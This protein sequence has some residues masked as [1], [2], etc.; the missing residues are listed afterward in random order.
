[1]SEEELFNMNKVAFA[2]LGRRYQY[3]YAE[4][5]FKENQLFKL[6]TDFWF[7]I[8]FKKGFNSKLFKSII[9][10]RNSMIP[11]QLVE[12]FNFLGIKQ[13]YELRKCNDINELSLVLTK[14]GEKFSTM[15]KKYE[16]ADTIIGM[17]SESLE[18]FTHYKDK[19]KETILI[20]YDSADDEYIFSDEKNK[21]PDWKSSFFNR[22]KKYYSRVYRE[23]DLADK[24]IV[25]STWTKNLI[26]NQGACEKKIHVIP[27]IHEKN[28]FLLES[29]SVNKKNTIKVLY[30]GSIVLRKGVQYLLEATN[31]LDNNK[32]EFHIIGSS[33][34]SHDT[35]RSMYP[36]VNFY[37]HVPFS[38]V[39]HFYKDSDVLVFPTLSDGFG[40]VQVE[41][42]SYGIPVIATTS[43]GDV[44]EHGCSG[45]LIP[46]NNSLEIENYL[47]LFEDDRELL[48]QMKINAKRRSKD[49][50]LENISN[51][52]IEILKK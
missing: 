17:C 47:R 33:L 42:M 20:Q 50:S 16:I 29:K 38:D 40:S 25:N 3:K 8:D 45:F 21:F 14:Y 27:L 23:W 34:I 24:I 6:Y 32:F 11:N 41:A 10:R 2:Q 31:K 9:E 46:P 18:I 39:V 13:S 28:S 51:L 12:S 37:E 22:S 5:L 44:V 48:Q 4:I 35:L 19:G 43:C 52:F 15:Q 7:P 1:M 36:H 49:F 30:V 26:I